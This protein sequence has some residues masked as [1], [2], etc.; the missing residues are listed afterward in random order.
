MNLSKKDIQLILL[1]FIIIG[2]S[3]VTIILGTKNLGVSIFENKN[4]DFPLALFSYFISIM[5]F[6]WTAIKFD[7]LR[8]FHKIVETWITLLLIYI[9][10]IIAL[11]IFGV[12]DQG[13]LFILEGLGTL[14]AF[15]I[16]QINFLFMYFKN[17]KI[18][19]K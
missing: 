3:I 8:H 9:L 4:P 11:L 5:G 14:I 17:R 1:T 18:K 16:L 6:I 10:S 12:R 19:E 7:F 13:L 15:G 2:G